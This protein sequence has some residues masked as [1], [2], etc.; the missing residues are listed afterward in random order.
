[1]I[2]HHSP[3]LAQV[4]RA[5]HEV[6]FRLTPEQAL[7]ATAWAAEKMVADPHGHPQY[8]T[9]T[10]YLDTPDLKTFRREPGFRQTKYRIRRYGAEE[11]LYLERKTKQGTRVQKVRESLALA[12]LECL[13]DPC[14]T[15]LAFAHA[16]RAKGLV[17]Q[18]LGRYERRAFSGISSSGSTRLTLDRN[19]QVA[20]STSYSFEAPAQW[21]A[22]PE[23]VMELKFVDGLP[24]QFR[25]LLAELGLNQT[26]FSKFRQGLRALRAED[27]NA[28]V[29]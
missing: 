19:I 8:E 25:V 13:T 26:T 21:E 18:M 16:V 2:S 6:K 28:T 22:L 14:E 15:E 11:M 4:G 9:T 10:L 27:Q 7:A 17:P 5:A 20:A 23:L 29:A 12:N 24:A 3:S 1:M